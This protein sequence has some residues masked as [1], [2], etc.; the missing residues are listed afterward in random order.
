MPG[1]RVPCLMP[2]SC[3]PSRLPAAYIAFHTM[4][5]QP[6]GQLAQNS[7]LGLQACTWYRLVERKAVMKPAVTCNH[8]HS[9][10]TNSRP[11]QKLCHTHYLIATVW[12]GSQMHIAAARRPLEIVTVVE[13]HHQVTWLSQNWALAFCLRKCCCVAAGEV[14]FLHGKPRCKTTFQ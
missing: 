4:M 9:I 1:P 12:Q 10:S 6:L 13:V 2:R 5:V 11:L 3:Q 14:E 8:V 7:S